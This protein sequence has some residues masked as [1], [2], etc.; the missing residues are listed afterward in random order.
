KR[1][2]RELERTDSLRS[3][4][5]AN[6]TTEYRFTGTTAPVFAVGCDDAVF[7]LRMPIEDCRMIVTPVT[8]DPQAI[9]WLNMKF[10]DCNLFIVEVG[11]VLALKYV[12]AAV[13]PC[14]SQVFVGK[15]SKHSAKLSAIEEIFAA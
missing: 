6:G 8:R 11:K 2:P 4:Q 3:R 13:K 1:I 7:V 12:P 14:L 15:G 9:Q 10:C 5:G